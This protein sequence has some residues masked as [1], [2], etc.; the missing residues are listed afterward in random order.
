[1]ASSGISFS[2]KRLAE[3]MGWDEDAIVLAKNGSVVSFAET[4]RA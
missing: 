2:I 1:M 4:L 3:S